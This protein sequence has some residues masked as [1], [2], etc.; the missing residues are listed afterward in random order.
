MKQ[1]KEFLRN[2][3]IQFQTRIAELYQ[4]LNEQ[5]HQFRK[6]EQELL[7]SLLEIMDDFE[8]L[9]S[10]IHS[11]EETFDK[12]TRILTKSMRSIHKKVIRFLKSRNIVKI[13]FP[14]NKANIKYCKVLDTRESIDQENESIISIVKEGYLDTK[15]EIVIRKAEVITVLNE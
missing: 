10:N 12:T 14:N 3:F 9:E 11:K 8:N 2:K 15:Q 4:T 1:E 6:R 13:E 7:S 5:E